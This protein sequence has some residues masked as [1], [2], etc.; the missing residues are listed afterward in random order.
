MKW[1]SVDDRLPEDGILVVFADIGHGTIYSTVA[2]SYRNETFFIDDGGL[3]AS[4]YDGGASIGL[5][6]TMDITHWMKL[7][8]PPTDGE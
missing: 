2:G 5:H 3:E 7:P 6:H 4:N 1:I 8:E